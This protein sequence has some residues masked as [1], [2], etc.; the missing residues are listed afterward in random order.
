MIKSFT[1][2]TTEADD[3]DLALEDLRSQ[4]DLN[5]G[6]L[7]NSVAIVS[8]YADFVDTGVF[9][10]VC[11]M[12][13]CD[14]VGTTTITSS[15]P[16][17]GN[18]IQLTLMIMT[19]DDVFFSTGFSEPIDSENE[20]P[21]KAAYAA[22]KAALSGE[23]ALAL[24]F[25]PLMM[26]VGGDFFVKAFDKVSGGVPNFGTLSVDHTDDYHKA[27]VLY[28]GIAAPDRYAFVLLSG[29]VNPK[30]FIATISNEK[31]FQEKGVV[32]ASQGSQLQTVNNLP[33]V[34]YLEGLGL[35]KDES[36]TIPGVNSFPFIM[37]QN[38]GMMPVVRVMFALTPDGSAVCGGDMPVGSTLSVS[39]INADEVVST[40]EAAL[41]QTMASGKHD[42]LL[43]YSCIGRYF[44]L[45]HN[46]DSEIDKVRSVLDHTGTPYHFAYSGCEIC[47]V[48]AQDGGRNTVNRTHNVTMIICAL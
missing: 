37:D 47:P 27:Q 40:S 28:N 33:V 7:R 38:D 6:L 9:A 48:Y 44:Y 35:T 16:G 41:L 8:C 42:C 31:V 20:A 29:N 36:G 24:S 26:N 15:V 5:G 22:A 13:P 34:D 19:S 12:L 46:P 11:D 45:G 14:V 10:A 2:F 1:A 23:P 32:T 25:V 43:I 4:I 39:S 3:I 21:I 17:S 18:D 30:F